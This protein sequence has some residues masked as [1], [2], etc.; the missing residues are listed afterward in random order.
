MPTILLKQFLLA[1]AVSVKAEDKSNSSSTD[2]NNFQI[3][4]L[5]QKKTF[6][7]YF[8]FILLLLLFIAL[9]VRID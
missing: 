6:H 1:T 8:I 2:S 3:H 5:T 7:S 9:I 4:L